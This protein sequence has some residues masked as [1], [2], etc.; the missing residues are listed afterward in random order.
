[1]I[2]SKLH[3][4]NH[5][6]NN[7]SLDSDIGV[8]FEDRKH[9]LNLLSVLIAL[10]TL[11]MWPEEVKIA[12]VRREGYEI[13]AMLWAI[14]RVSRSLEVLEIFWKAMDGQCSLRFLKLAISKTLRWSS[15][16]DSRMR[17]Q[18]HSLTR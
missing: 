12:R 18:C 2:S 11:S 10:L 17:R 7:E 13:S 15:F 8:P 4:L 1:M 6:T 5:E 9:I 3:Y 14:D 16:M